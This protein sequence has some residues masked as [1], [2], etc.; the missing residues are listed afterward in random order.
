M[1]II[2]APRGES[3]PAWA[4]G[5]GEQSSDGQSTLK[6][7]VTYLAA[8]VVTSLLISSVFK[9][10]KYDLH[11]PLNVDPDALLHEM[12]V[13]NFAEGH[14]YVNPWLGA[15]G[16]LQL[17]DFP[18]PH[19][20]HLIVW[21]ILRLFTHSF[22][23]IL[24]LY[25]FLS[26]P[27]CALTSVFALRRLGISRRFAL[28]GAV[29]FALLPF[30]IVRGESH[31]FLSVLYIVPLAAMVIIWIAMGQPLF[32]YELPRDAGRRPF[33]TR[34]GVIALISCVLT[35]WDHPYYAFFTVGLL[36]IAGVVGF[37]R[38]GHRKALLTSCVMCIVVTGALSTAVLPDIIFFQNHGRT[39]VANRLPGESELNPLTLL[40]LLAPIRNHRVQWLAKARDY[41]DTHSPR[42]SEGW[43]ESLGILGSV[44]FLMSLACFFRKRCSDFLY[45]LGILN[46]TALLAGVMG[47]LG[48]IFAFLVSPQIRAYN[49]ISVFI[50]F[51]SIAAL[52]WALDRWIPSANLNWFGLSIVPGL[53]ITIAVLDQVPHGILLKNRPIH[54]AAFYGEDRFI[55]R[56]EQSVPPNS[57]ILQLPYL[58]FPESGPVNRMQDYDPF[59]GYLHSKALRWSYGAMRER[60][61][62][63]WLAKLSAEPTEQLVASASHA[64]FAGI[65]VDRFGYQDMAADMEAKLKSLLHVEPW[66]DFTGRYLYFP[67]PGKI[68]SL[69]R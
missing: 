43:T 36:L 47:G 64:G 45:S 42:V 40:E 58:A 4:A 22:G 23:V 32:G 46:L 17:Y 52:V 19:W 68:G 9:L 56:I 15:P 13:K 66:S 11:V 16:Q 21:S 38:N 54:E 63:S 7:V 60:D 51:F 5:P 14:F 18:L 6:S 24:N 55:Q 20:T 31:L 30:H 37:F 61:A 1:K 34:D 26:F 3:A 29:V 69:D 35:G 67:L 65:W 49:R 28:A 59:L 41:Y 2:N 62:D 12:I 33:I 57:M 27:L 25:Y 39:S 10:W 53:L 8:F 44:G 50:G 48:A